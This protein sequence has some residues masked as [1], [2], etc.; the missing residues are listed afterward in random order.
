MG[1]HETGYPRIPRDL[2]PTP[3]W[4]VEAL[5]EHVSVKGL[6]ILEPA[7]GRGHMSE[8]LKAAGAIVHSTDIEDYGYAGLD[9]LADFTSFNRIEFCL[10]AVITNPPFGLR[11][12]LAEAFIETGLTLV[13]A[14][15]MAL[16]LP[17]DFDSAKTR[18][19]L[20]GDCPRFAGK[21]VLIRRIKWFN[22]PGKNKCPKENSAWFLRG[23]V[24]L[25]SHPAPVI[26][27]APSGAREAPSPTFAP[28]MVS[29]HSM[30]A[31][32]SAKAPSHRL[33]ALFPAQ[34]APPGAQP[35]LKTSKQKSPNREIQ[36]DK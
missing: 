13:G 20:F 2:Y 11:G 9:G 6:R 36:N 27:Y 21:I 28:V 19:H 18:R 26:C 31:S 4:P 3:A 1:K 23:D 15:F 5:F 8:V 17:A 29:R 7:C 33:P 24:C 35:G 30:M 14:G 34:A 12:K 16:L 22:Q 32:V 25:K 10:D